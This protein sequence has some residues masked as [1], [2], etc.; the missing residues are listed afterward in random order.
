[1]RAHPG[2]DCRPARRNQRAS[3]PD[4]IGR[5]EQ[6]A[7]AEAA[8][9]VAR[10]P[11]RIRRL[12]SCACKFKR[13]ARERLDVALVRRGLAETRERAHALILAGAVQVD[14]VAATRPAQSVAAEA[15]LRVEPAG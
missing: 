10:V 8:A 9:Q 15:A 3:A 12:T 11:G 4:R 14:G 2:R 7:P 5:L 1:P 13:V 6:A